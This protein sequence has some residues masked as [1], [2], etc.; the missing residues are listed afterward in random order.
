MVATWKFIR[1]GKYIITYLTKRVFVA[2]V[3]LALKLGS[4]KIISNGFN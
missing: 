3:E 1:K 2:R 4:G